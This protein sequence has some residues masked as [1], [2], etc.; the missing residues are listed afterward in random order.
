MIPVLLD[1]EEV[2]DTFGLS[3]P[4]DPNRLAL[5]REEQI[6]EVAHSSRI[7]L[8]HGDRVAPHVVFLALQTIHG[9]IYHKYYVP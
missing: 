8:A 1:S 5:G 7:K 9:V 2:A 3:Q 4:V 6:A